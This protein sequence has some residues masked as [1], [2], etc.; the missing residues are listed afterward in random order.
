[1]NRILDYIVNSIIYWS[2]GD[3][4]IV[5]FLAGS[6]AA[7]LTFL[8]ALPAL[9]GK[10]MSDKFM[11]A[12]MGFSGGVMITASFTSLIFPALEAGPFTNVV[13]GFSLGAIAI[14]LADRFLPHEHLIK[15][16]E[17]SEALRSRLKAAWL[18]AIAIIIHNFPEG[19]AIG[20]SMSFDIE[21]GVITAIA[22]G[23]QDIPEG[24]AVALPLAGI[25]GKVGKA[26]A[27]A[28]LSG[29][30]EP[31]M[32]LIPPLLVEQSILLLPYILS[33]A[34]GA[35]VYVVSHEVIPETHRHGFE[36]EA[37]LG[38][39]LGFLLMLSLDT[40]LG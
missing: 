12:A 22:I 2:G 13:V 4:I 39:L 1:M 29:I 10:R 37:T 28:A 15:G 20:S 8:G 38:F 21:L 23:I 7:V 16:F 34:A 19:L 6:I 36:G 3:L 33:F 27:L 14:F 5:A 35:M 24:L 26:L 17:G 18:I 40:L 32:A 31:L 11:D 25:E 30:V 9:A